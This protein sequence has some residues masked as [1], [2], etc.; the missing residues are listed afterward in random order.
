[1][2]KL[3]LK[4]MFPK[5]LNDDILIASGD[6]AP[7]NLPNCNIIFPQYVVEV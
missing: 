7:S 3:D 1:M 4:K 5:N 2:P 6:M